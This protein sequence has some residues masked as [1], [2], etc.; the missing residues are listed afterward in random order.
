MTRPAMGRVMACINNLVI[1]LLNR[2][3]FGNHAQARRQL[4]ADPAKALAIILGL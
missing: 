3:G 2:Q 4:D 1:G